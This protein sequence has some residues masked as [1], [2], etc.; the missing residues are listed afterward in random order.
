MIN[1]FLVLSVVIF[2]KFSFQTVNAA[3]SQKFLIASKFKSNISF[4]GSLLLCKFF[5]VNFHHQTNKLC[6]NVSILGAEYKQINNLAFSYGISLGKCAVIGMLIA[7]R[8]LQHFLHACLTVFLLKLIWKT[9]LNVAASFL[10]AY[11]VVILVDCFAVVDRDDTVNE[12]DNFS[13]L[14]LDLI[15]TLGLVKLTWSL[16]QGHRWYVIFDQQFFLPQ[17]SSAVYNYYW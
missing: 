3:F 10:F 12:E 8:H 16:R 14:C 9:I 15:S 4:Y 1:Y 5:V 2:S 17:T 13:H 6:K 7:L 11:F